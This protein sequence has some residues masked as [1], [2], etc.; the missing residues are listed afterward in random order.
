MILVPI[1]IFYHINLGL[2]NLSKTS[3]IK[4]S[5]AIARRRQLSENKKIYENDSRKYSCCRLT[6]QTWCLAFGK[7]NRILFLAIFDR[8][9]NCFNKIMANWCFNEHFKVNDFSSL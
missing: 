4:K 6:N 8:A 2:I 9:I 7:E 3:K 5:I 1:N